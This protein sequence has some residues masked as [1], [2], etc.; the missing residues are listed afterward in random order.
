MRMTWIAAAVLAI[1]PLAFAQQAVW[2]QQKGDDVVIVQGGIA[3]G[4]V[5]VNGE[6]LMITQFAGR[7]VKG[8][9]YSAEA[10][11]ETIQ[12]L[13]DGNRI[14]NKSAVRM[15]RDSEGRTRTETTVQPLGPWV[16]DGKSVSITTIHDPV[17][18]E[19]ITLHNDSKTATKAITRTL[20][21][22]QESADGKTVETET[23]SEMKF[24]V[25]VPPPPG[26]DP[27]QGDV[28][29]QGPA[30]MKFR[31]A[32]PAEGLAFIPEG[33][34]EKSSLGKKVIEGVECE[35]T[36]E[37]VTIAAG[38]AGNERDIQIVTERWYSPELQMDLFRKH[39][40]PRFGETTYR[41]SGLVRGEQQRTLF[42]VP[43][44]F[45]T[46]EIGGTVDIKGERRQH[47]VH[48]TV[49]KQDPQIF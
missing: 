18:G 35:G 7:P 36:K 47:E 24:N 25:R 15:F 13:A 12:S 2:H 39:N 43:A 37:V 46:H 48:V 27:A 9:P 23:T 21:H 40:D 28:L 19:H 45:E 17:S 32:T 26:V 11:T 3:A 31:Q 44:G 1:A 41:V 29:F 14:V 8:A 38:K 22:T 16:A 33:A 20:I 10:V 49:E 4:G 5:P 6:R 30:R 34:V 42:E